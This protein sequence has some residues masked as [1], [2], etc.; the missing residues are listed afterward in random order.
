MSVQIAL[1]LYMNK[2]KSTYALLCSAAFRPPYRPPVI[3]HPPLYN[4]LGIP[5]TVYR[6]WICLILFGTFFSFRA[7]IRTIVFILHSG[8]ER[9]AANNIVLPLPLA[10]LAYLKHHFSMF[11][12]YSSSNIIKYYKLILPVLMQV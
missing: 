2:K 11:F 3:I 4:F 5:Y 12:M 10:P 7:I 8:N 1:L 6:I 9:T